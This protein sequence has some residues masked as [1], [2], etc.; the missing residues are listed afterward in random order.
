MLKRCIIAHD[1]GVGLDQFIPYM[2]HF[3]R[4]YRTGALEFWALTGAR[5][6]GN[7]AS[8]RWPSLLFY[9][10]F[11]QENRLVLFE[12]KS[13]RLDM[14]S[15]ERDRNGILIPTNRM[16]MRSFFVET[17]FLSFCALHCTAHHT[18]VRDCSGRLWMFG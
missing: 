2:S 5:F 7:R 10:F 9:V 16:A 11:R 15:W 17:C 12:E 3:N 1:T 18:L 4:F 8:K 6:R 14:S 13:N